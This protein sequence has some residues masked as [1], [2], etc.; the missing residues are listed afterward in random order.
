MNITINLPD[1]LG[2]EV[3][4]LSNRDAFLLGVVRSGLKKHWLDEQTKI[5]LQ[6]ADSGD[7]ADE[8]EVQAFFAK[9]GSNGN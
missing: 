8:R 6:Q 5:S 3:E 4:S 9:W 7:Y 1:D 2:K